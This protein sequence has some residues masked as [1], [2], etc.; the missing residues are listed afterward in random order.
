MVLKYR[1]T[2]KVKTYVRHNA[3]TY[4]PLAAESIESTIEIKIAR[5]SSVGA[6]RFY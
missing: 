1:T 4:D 6:C 3:L 2:Y 5:T